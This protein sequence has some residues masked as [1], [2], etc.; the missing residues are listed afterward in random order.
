MIPA[1]YLLKPAALRP[2]SVTNATVHHIYSVSTCIT[3]S[4]ADYIKYWKHNGFW[5]FDRT[6]DIDEICA[7]EGISKHGL[8]LFYYEAHEQEFRPEQKKWSVFAPEPTLATKVE[9]PECARLEGFD[10]VSFSSSQSPECSPLS[11]NAL[12][13]DVSV[14][15]HCLFPTLH[16]AITALDGGVFDDA[17]P[18]PFRVFA[19]Y[20]V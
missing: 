15:Q 3:G 16:D 12:A 6:S 18:G 20:S 11:C 2:V 14:N 8:N 9:R 1:G 19:V 13:N 10:V 5:F 4:F 7:T 17:E